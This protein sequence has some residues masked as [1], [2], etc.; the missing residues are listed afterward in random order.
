MTSSKANQIG[1]W[2]KDDLFSESTPL[3]HWLVNGIFPLLSFVAVCT[4]GQNFR[5]ERC[6]SCKASVE[7]SKFLLNFETL[8]SVAALT[9]RGC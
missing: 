4:Y 8:A 6:T 1:Q 9:Q 7:L 3:E 2:S 5:F